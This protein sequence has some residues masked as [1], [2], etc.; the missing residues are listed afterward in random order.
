[1]VGHQLHPVRAI[2]VDIGKVDLTIK[3]NLRKRIGK[4]IL[5]EVIRI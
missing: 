4:R 5:S 2:L 3:S 1:M